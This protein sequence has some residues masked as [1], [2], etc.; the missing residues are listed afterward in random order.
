MD[1]PGQVD[2]LL[3]VLFGQN[4]GAAG[5]LAHQGDPLHV[6]EVEQIGGRRR[7]GQGLAL[8][9]GEPYPLVPV[10]GCDDLVEVQADDS[11]DG[12]NGLQRGD[13]RLTA[14]GVPVPLQHGDISLT[15]S[16]PVGKLLHGHVVLCAVGLDEV[17]QGHADHLS[18]LLVS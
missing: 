4:G 7:G 14:F 12:A 16:T 18:C 1:V 3:N 17:A 2:I 10:Q 11:A 8:G 15:Q 13:G 6:G 5:D 9:E